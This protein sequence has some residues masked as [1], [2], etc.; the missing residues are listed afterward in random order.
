MLEGR[1]AKNGV[2]EAREGG[3]KLSTDLNPSEFGTGSRRE[4]PCNASGAD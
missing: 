1:Q 3:A 4:I 2:V